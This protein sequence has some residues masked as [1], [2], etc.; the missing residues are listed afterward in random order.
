MVTSFG[1]LSGK[2]R[3]FPPSRVRVDSFDLG[4]RRAIIERLVCLSSAVV[5]GTLP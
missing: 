3:P 1:S 2:Q 5:V 4:Y